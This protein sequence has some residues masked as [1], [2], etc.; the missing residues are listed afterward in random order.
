M[1]DY[2]PLIRAYLSCTPRDAPGWRNG[3]VT[4]VYINQ[5]PT[6]NKSISLYQGARLTGR[7]GTENVVTRS[8]WGPTPP[9]FDQLPRT[10][11]VL[12]APGADILSRDIEL[13]G[14]VLRIVDGDRSL[15]P[16]VGKNGISDE[17]VV[18]PL[19]YG[20]AVYSAA[21]APACMTL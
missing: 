20:F 9:P 15:P 5:D 8:P 2:D 1:G 21:K 17:W 16:L 11:F 3:A 14:K 13:N 18:P 19:S 4:L 7:L 6:N 10:E 12:T